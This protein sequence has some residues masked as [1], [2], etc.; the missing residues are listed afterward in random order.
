M[1]YVSSIGWK[2]AV[3]LTLSSL[4][5]AGQTSPSTATPDAPRAASVTN[6]ASPANVAAQSAVPSK[7]AAP[8]Q[9]LPQQIAAMPR[10]VNPGI[11]TTAQGKAMLEHLNDVLRF[12][13]ASTTQIQK[14]GEPSDALY[15]EQASQHAAQIGQTAFQSARNLA[16]LFNRLQ[17]GSTASGG[18]QSTQP[19]DDTDNDNTQPQEPTTAQRLTAA[20]ARVQARIADLAAQDA[21]LDKQIS[22]AKGKNLAAL[23]QRDEQLEGQLELQKAMLDAMTR[24]SSM[25]DAQT[26]TGLAGDV[27]R[28]L[29]AAPELASSSKSVTAPP[30]LES[31][32]TVRES[33]VSTQ[34]IALFQLLGARRDIESRIHELDVLKKQANDLR[35]PIRSLLRS[36]IQQGDAAMQSPANL[37]DA[38]ALRATRKH[39]D[40]LSST[41][42]VLS[43]ATLP[44]SQ[45][46]LLLESARANLVS[47]RT[48]VN[49]EYVTL[50]RSL[51][52]RVVSIA[53]SLLVLFLVSGVWQRL[54]A[55]YVRDIR[56]R[57]QILIIRRTVLGFLT[58]V[59]L[60]FGFVTQFSSLATFAGFITAGIAVGL[61]TILLSVA[62][63]FFIVGRYGVRVGDRITVAGVTGDVIEVGLVRF[64]MS[65]LTGTGTELHPTGRVA[66]FANSVLFQSGTPLYKQMP[67]TEYAWHE[68]TVKLKADADYRAATDAILN[69]V[70]TTYNTYRASIEAQHQNVEQWMDAPVEKPGIEPRLQLTD[71]GLQYAVLFPVEIK[72]AS[73]TDEAM[74]HTLLHDMENNEALK[75][76]IAAPPQVK[77]VVKG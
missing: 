33:G 27:E 16:A 37:S 66:V 47:W 1:K 51:L 64:Y 30:V 52:L 48:V 34:A 2:F 19:T 50:L 57:R 38:E 14:V 7:S 75:N 12:Y 70:T 76:G 15:G 43:T 74:I 5:V 13:R 46:V 4:P 31:L 55:K 8:A 59:V 36:T 6:S 24:L 73:S 29:R 68:L 10:L 3:V 40:A 61:Q 21:V 67:G 54:T 72:N 28:L 45:E 11:D 56:R 44:S 65:E 23:Q 35:A 63:Y 77:A 49:A 18:A 17:P 25:A 62:A 20:R 41:F 22:T 71:A 39:Y 42:R 58:G 9:T 32:S 69:A 53:L 26:A 60:I